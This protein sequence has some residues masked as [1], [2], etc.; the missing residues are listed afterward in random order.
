MDLRSHQ[1]KTMEGI[2]KYIIDLVFQ[3]GSSLRLVPVI[4]GSLCALLVL[5]GLLGYYET[6]GSIHVK[7][8]RRGMRRRRIMAHAAA[9]HC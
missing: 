2:G 1:M 5:L 4:N 6:I 8:R 7:V 9:I 3:P